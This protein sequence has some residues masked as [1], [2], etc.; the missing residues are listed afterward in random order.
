MDGTNQGFTLI[1]PELFADMTWAVGVAYILTLW[2]IYLIE[3]KVKL[4]RPVQFAVF[5]VL[6][7]GLQFVTFGTCYPEYG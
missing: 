6:V 5:A 4:S 2:A 3:K 1:N 7:L